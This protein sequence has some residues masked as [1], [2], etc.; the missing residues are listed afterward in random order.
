MVSSVQSPA[1]AAS[2]QPL[3]ESEEPFEQID[4]Q[5]CIANIGPRE[6][7]RRL[8]SGIVLLSLGVGI[9]AVLV[10]S[11]VPSL[12]RLPLFVLFYAGAAGVFQWREK[13]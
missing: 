5:V 13:T 9:G 8:T 2:R 6:R 4:G 3:Q 10:V 12:W 1:F 11:H 7:R